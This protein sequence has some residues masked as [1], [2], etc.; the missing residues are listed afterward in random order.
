M[1]RMTSLNRRNASQPKLI[2]LIL[3]ILAIGG[4]YWFSAGF[5][6]AKRQ[7][8]HVSTCDEAPQLLKDTLGLSPEQTQQILATH[9]SNNGC[10][11]DRRIDSLVILVV[12]ALRFDFARYSL[13]LSV[14]A[15]IGMDG[16]RIGQTHQ[17]INTKTNRT[18]SS[19]LLQFV[20][21]PPTVTMQRLKGLT[22]GSLPTFADI[23]GNMGGATIDEDSWVQQLIDSPFQ[24]RGL[25][26]P[27]RLGFV[28]DDTWVDLFPTQFE[29]SHPFPSFNTRDLDT[30]D[31]GC[32]KELPRLLQH[33]RTTGERPDELEVLV[34]HFLGVDHV[35]HTYGP[36]DQHMTAKLNQMDAALSTTL[37]LLDES[38]N[39]HLALIFGDHGMTED[40]NH[41]G[42]T[43]NEINA[44]LFV[45][46]SPACGD[47]PLDLAPQMGSKY[48]QDAFQS[49]HQID[50]VPTISILLG[51]PIPYANLGGI[52]PT[53]LGYEQIAATTAALALNAAQVWRYFTMY[54]KT[55]NKLPNLPALKE[56]LDDAV[57]V[58]KQALAHPDA[59]DSDAF[60]KAS[61]LFKI[62]LT[63]AAELGHQ[64]WTRFDTV[65]MFLGACLIFVTLVLWVVLLYL[66]APSLRWPTINHWIEIGLSTLFVF[67]QSGML[68]FSNSY[69]EAEQSIV[70]FMLGMIGFAI[71]VR[72][73]LVKAG[74]N[75][76]IIPH[77]PLLI[78]LLSRLSEFFVSGHGQDPS[79]R[80]HWAHNTYVFLSSLIGLIFLRILWW[81]RLVKKP[82]LGRSITL[83]GVFHV[84][85]D[86]LTV[87]FLALGWIEKRSRDHSQNGYV[88]MRIAIALVL[89]SFLIT[90][91]Q[92]FSPQKTAIQDEDSTD[93]GKTCSSPRTHNLQ[94]LSKGLSNVSKLLILIMVV[95]GPAAAPTVLLACLQGWMLYLLCR[96][97]G[98][99]EVCNECLVLFGS[100]NTSTKS[101]FSNTCLDYR[102]HYQ[103]WQLYGA[104]LY[105]IFFLRRTMDVHSIGCSIQQHSLLRWNSISDWVGCNFSS[106]HL[107]GRSLE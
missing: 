55:A 101:T 18:T 70:M 29:E 103:F 47:M 60:Y 68:S 30:V 39:C 2:D 76:A 107:A 46:F 57:E 96:A 81:Y 56:Q 54:S 62:F 32:L 93:G 37:E 73:T 75:A 48:I 40:G 6:L 85:T 21:D 22:T 67:F 36:H 83:C 27:S 1:A 14:G 66:Q 33:V 19:Q 102:Y 99:Y 34:A 91:Y 23:S 50:L 74:G 100:R 26:F 49:I 94:L 24:R 63:E 45:H 80:L 86:V 78:P 15:R 51:L 104:L 53:L 9:N 98:F 87:L 7:L 8:P 105:D 4:L 13:P 95:T 43:D 64:V 38:A 90:I 92:A 61:G 71:Y 65:A 72:M 89:S 12:D 31:N 52:A 84:L 17:H 77:I 106:T 3:P 5:F 25:K 44:A 82:A 11:L 88:W 97:T 16:P 58:Y 59:S 79:I 41:G 28:G 69:I 10:W 42:G 35:G 20:A